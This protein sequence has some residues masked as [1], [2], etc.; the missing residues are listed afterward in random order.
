MIE[1]RLRD[2]IAQ[3]IDEADALAAMAVE[4]DKGYAEATAWLVETLNVV[5]L[6]LPDPFQPFRFQIELTARQTMSSV[7]VLTI[8]ATLRSLLKDVDRGLV[9][10]I[11]NK[12]RGET[13]DDLLDLAVA[14]RGRDGKDQ[15]GAV[16]SIVFEDT[17]RKIY[18]DKIDKVA[19]PELEQVTIAL[20]KK[21]V[22]T[23]EQAAQARAA[24]LVR[25]KA[26][27]AN[28]NGF[29]MDGVDA[30]IKITKAL[31]EAYLK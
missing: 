25:N 18:A 19:Q 6:A 26:L 28:W 16:V 17:M 27:H 7:K 22:I 13:F 21:E 15:A 30:T 9:G 12:I 10:T 11:T 2:K 14:Y 20:T 31:I 24:A 23:E 5:K 8:A 3:L 4:T 1:K 29:T